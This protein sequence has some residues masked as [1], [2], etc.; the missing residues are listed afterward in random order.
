MLCSA[1][2]RAMS[3]ESCNSD[4]LKLACIETITRGLK[5]RK[6]N[7]KE[8]CIQCYCCL[9]VTERRGG[10]IPLQPIPEIREQLGKSEARKGGTIHFKLRLYL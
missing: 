8:R 5:V 7:D 1:D 3:F 6:Q 4:S 10:K 2:L 9:D